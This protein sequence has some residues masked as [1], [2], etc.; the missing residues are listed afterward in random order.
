MFSAQAD[1][2]PEKL[3]Q[4]IIQASYYH[5]KFRGFNDQAISAGCRDLDLPSVSGTLLR[6]GPYDIVTFAMDEWLNQMKADIVRYHK[7]VEDEETGE[8]KE[9]RFE[10]LDVT[11]KLH[12]GIKRRLQEMSR[13]VGTW[14]QAMALGLRPQHLPSTLS[15][16]YQ[17]SDEIW[18]LAGDRSTDHKYY[19]RRHNLLKVYCLTEIYMLQDKS[20]HFKDTWVFLDKRLEEMEKFDSLL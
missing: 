6:N 8:K 13:Y 5:A 4:K 20:D 10:D 11:H 16:L 14:P 17:L 19:M 7:A 1:E 18:Y 15:K 2:D 9:I 12:V 3:R